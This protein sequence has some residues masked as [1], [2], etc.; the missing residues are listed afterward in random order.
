M[1][2][3][4]YFYSI[5]SFKHLLLLLHALFVQ[6]EI[7]L[8]YTFSSL[9]SLQDETA[10]S[11]VFGI[12]PIKKH[13]LRRQER[14]LVKKKDTKHVVA[15]WGKT[16]FYIDFVLFVDLP[17]LFIYFCSQLSF[18]M[19]RWSCSVICKTTNLSLH[20]ELRP[21]QPTQG[22]SWSNI[23]FSGRE[24]ERKPPSQLGWSVWIARYV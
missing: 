16:Y 10:A 20:Q 12:T 4:N 19:Y 8:Y 15:W 2:F 7:G 14:H 13:L 9:L 6:H 17:F 24:P 5:Y 11:R 22:V 23:F 18:M 21:A 3:L 1:F